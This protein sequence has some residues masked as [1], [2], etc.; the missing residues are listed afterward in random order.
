MLSSESYNQNIENKHFI[1]LNFSEIVFVLSL[2]KTL[3]NRSM[4]LNQ[5][6][7]QVDFR[8][9]LKRYDKTKLFRIRKANIELIFSKSEIMK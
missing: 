6:K 4:Q 1:L 5:L 8:V 2:E 7:L 9:H 3:E